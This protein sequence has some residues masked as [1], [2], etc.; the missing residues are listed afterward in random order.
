MKEKD[1]KETIGKKLEE[2]YLAKPMGQAP[3]EET[4]AKWIAIVDQRRVERRRR[5]KKIISCAAA[6]ALCVCIGVTCVVKPP[7]AVAGGSGGGKIETSLNTNDT[8]VSLDE[9]PTDI[10]NKYLIF[11][12][13]PE[14]Y[15]FVEANVTSDGAL[16]K[17]RIL[18]DNETSNEE[19][20]VTQISG[21]EANTVSSVINE[22]GRQEEWGDMT[23]YINEYSSGDEE[24]VY[25]FLY[26]EM[27]VKINAPSNI[28]SSEIRSIVEKTVRN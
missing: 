21:D 1:L 26:N 12:D 27:V 6:C 14:G 9:I 15:K 13:L 5:K 19:I 4:V 18:Y 17:I 28:E 20:F 2:A 3:S 24:V 23:V 11:V 7:N 8:Y 25:K 22:G 16:E 10:K